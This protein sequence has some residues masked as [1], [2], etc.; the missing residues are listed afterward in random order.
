MNLSIFPDN[1]D[2][3]LGAN[4]KI[5]FDVKASKWLTNA[6]LAPIDV[7]SVTTMSE[8]SAQKMFASLLVG[9]TVFSTL[10]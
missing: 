3:L 1:S 9:A 4:E 2:G 7:T 6:D 5:H 8:L 10:Y